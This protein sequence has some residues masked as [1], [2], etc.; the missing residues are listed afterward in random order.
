[1]PSIMQVNGTCPL[2]PHGNT[3]SAGRVTRA[4]R[5]ADGTPGP[6]SRV[7]LR[8]AVRAV[9]EAAPT[10]GGG[11]LRPRGGGDGG[12]AAACLGPGGTPERPW[13]SGGPVPAAGQGRRASRGPLRTDLGGSG[14]G[15]TEDL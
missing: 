14:A 4:S 2:T 11:E 7:P 9:M 5:A 6:R 13:G 8:P 15:E 1:M 3:R 12:N 10:H